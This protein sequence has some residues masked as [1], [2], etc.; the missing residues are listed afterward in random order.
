[1][2]NISFSEEDIALFS[3]QDLLDISKMDESVLTV[4]PVLTNS[5][6]EFIV[7]PH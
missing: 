3:Y 7:K 1:M 4:W 2:I 5:M 6:M